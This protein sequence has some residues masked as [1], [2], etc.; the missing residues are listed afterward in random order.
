MSQIG[1]SLGYEGHILPPLSLFLIPYHLGILC[2]F[3]KLLPQAEEQKWGVSVSEGQLGFCK[4]LFLRVLST[5][6]SYR[7]MIE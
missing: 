1:A 4:E 7:R 6:Y 5:V 2:Y 3:R